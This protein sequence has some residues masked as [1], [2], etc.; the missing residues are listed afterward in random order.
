VDRW[1]QVYSFM[2]LKILHIVG[3]M[4]R[5]GVE[6][7]LMHMMRNIDRNRFEFHFLV[8]GNTEGD[9]D[10][11]IL[12]L[13]GKIH[14]GPTTRKLSQYANRFGDVVREHGPFAVLHSHVYW[15]SG[16]LMRLGYR[17]SIPVRIAHSH[18]ATSVPAWKIHRRLYQAAM[19]S[20]ISHYS[21]HRIGIS[22]QA[23][24][25]LFGHR[26]GK[27]F[28]LLYYGMDFAPFWRS[29]SPD[30]IKQRL[31]IARDRKI[32]GHVGRFFPVKN[33]SFIVDVFDR[34]IARGTNAHLLFVGDG[35]GMADIRTKIAGRG[36]E[37]RCTFTGVQSEVAPFLFA[38]DVFVLPSKWEGLSLVALEAQAA[39]VPVVASTN[40]PDEVDVISSLA[41]HLPLTIGA[42]GWA[43]A[44]TRRLQAPKLR[45]GNEPLLLQN[46]RFGLQTCLD[47]LSRIYAGNLY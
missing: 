32:I 10:R 20:L 21:T 16:F 38:M 15:Y 39:G 23:G 35:P 5:G 7:W 43:S 27:P 28:T 46:S 22:K 1:K 12:A 18:T 45:T 25:S 31:G 9:Y 40:V 8:G 11:E 47:G 42:D 13:G 37:D 14:Y 3:R 41:E 44:V 29:Y 36:L 26:P 17:A 33:H 4:S 6:T 2:P 24:E 19:R 34:V 30:Q